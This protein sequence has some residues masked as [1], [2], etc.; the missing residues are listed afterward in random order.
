[1]RTV[2]K[3]V[4]VVL[5]LLV[6]A[7]GGLLAW[8]RL[9][10]WPAVLIVRNSF[11][12][13]AQEAKASVAPFVPDDVVARHGL[14]YLAGE[15]DALLDLFVPEG[16]TAP[17]PLVVWVHGGGFIAGTRDDL[18]GYLKVLAD[19]G[20]AVAAIDYTLAPEARFPTPVR[21]TNAALA[22]LV[23][24]ATAFGLDPQRIFLAGDS[25]GAQIAA[26]AALGVAEPGYARSIG[27]TPSLPRN[28]LR[29]VVLFCGPYDPTRMDFDSPY[30]GFMR[31]V[32][33][34]YLGTRDPADPR[35]A[36]MS[37][38]PH[39]TS[40]FPPTFISVGNADPLAP[41]SYALA[42]AL[43][44]KGVE[45][46]TLFFPPRHEP[47]LGHEYQLLLSTRDGRLSFERFVAFLAAH[48]AAPAPAEADAGWRAV[49]RSP[50]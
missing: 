24:N 48:S 4:I 46:D 7:G 19:R 16:A 37:L 29:G 18:T 10:P 21:Q 1:M 33:W 40:A 22:W 8:Y 50:A 32:I 35:V 36:D 41:Q 13:G 20:Y 49:R 30:G 45:V 17:L 15:P 9:S 25:A 28:A 11:D 34:S 26:Q 5:A 38:L 42:E 12:A 6:L 23:Q 31:T 3:A 27:I 2:M 47:Q 39:L 43:E 14:S 44:A